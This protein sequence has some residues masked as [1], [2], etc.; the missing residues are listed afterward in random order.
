M[1]IVIKVGTN[2]LTVKDGS[3]NKGRISALAGALAALKSDG[4]EVVLVSSGAIGAGM[5]RMGLDTRPSSLRDKQA[6]AAIGQPLLMEA[7]QAAFSAL[8]LTTAQVLLTRQDFDDRARYINARN[9]ML[10]LLGMGALPVV[11]ENDT[12]AVEEINFG[13]NDT[14][15]ALV[16][17]KV[18]ADYLFILTDVE[19]LYRGLP[20]KSEIIPVVNKITPEIED[21]ASDKSGSGK[22]VGGMKTKISAARIA[23]A[24]GVKTVITSG[25]DPAVIGKIIKGHKAGTVFMP[26]SKAL[27]ARKCWIA[28]G[29]KC[30]GK[31]VIDDGAV[32]ALVKKGK[33]LLPSGIVSAQGTFGVG[34]TVG[35]FTVSGKEIG[36]GLASFSSSDLEKIKG[37]K[38]AEIRKLLPAADVEE[39][40]HRDNLVLL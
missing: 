22:G 39:A 13:D 24:A 17:A 15:A 12:V 1:R 38:T 14:L 26:S 29:A 36:R 31:I 34:D 10:A 16:A 27:E 7:Y 5:G 19:G 4:C 32:Q 11:N 23:T 6:L 33:S 8:D 9:T 21:Y 37:K 2:L 18:S 35:I 40:V 20:G 28:F 3:L 30:R 25:A